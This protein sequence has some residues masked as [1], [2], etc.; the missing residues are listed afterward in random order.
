[1]ASDEALVT[2]TI[3][4]WARSVLR[5]PVEIAAE[6]IGVSVDRLRDWES[7]KSHPTV[8]QLLKLSNVYK[9]SFA[10]FYLPQPP[11]PF[12]PPVTDYRRISLSRISEYSVSMIQEL[13]NATDRREILLELHQNWPDPFAKFP[14]T[15]DRDAERAG[16]KIRAGLDIS[17]VRQ[18][19]TA[20]SSGRP[21]FNLWREAIEQ[22]GILVF[23][24][25]TLDVEEMRGC[26]IVKSPLPI[27]MVNRKDAYTGRVFTLLHELVHVLL[28]TSGLCDL[29]DS[30][31]IP[32][33]DREIEAYCN[34]VASATLVPKDDLIKHPIVTSKDSD[35]WNLEELRQ[36]AATY[37]VSREMIMRRLVTLHLADESEYRRI[38]AILGTQSAQRDQSR[39]VAP[40]VNAVSSLGK[41]FVRSIIDAFNNEQITA[42]DV[43]DYLGVRIKHLN[44]VGE[45]VGYSI[46]R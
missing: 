35:E 7:G 27:I 42:S 32:I 36:I 11:E 19:E 38:R 13:R 22:S 45:L 17:L 30:N 21:S 44:R 6:K 20:D 12:V 5:M 14:K 1:M 18:K 8:K 28:R 25:I 16:K 4:I 41:P 40:S 10:V 29:D 33:H 31:E 34:R 15:L 2:P 43:A 24:A 26:S 9:Q 23:Q 46:S 37:G 3:L 39:G